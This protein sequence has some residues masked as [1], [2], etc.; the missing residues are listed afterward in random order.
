MIRHCSTPGANSKPNAA[1]PPLAR[2]PSSPRSNR[3]GWPSLTAASPPPTS[4]AN[5]CGSHRA[6]RS[7]RVRDAELL[8]HEVLPS[9]APAAG[10]SIPLLAEAQADG[11]ISPAHARVVYTVIEK[12]PDEI[13]DEH[14]TDIE[15]FL[16][17]PGPRVR[18]G[19]ARPSVAERLRATLDPDGTCQRSGPSGPPPRAALPPPPRRIGPPRSRVDRRVRRAPR[20]PPRRALPSRHR[21]RTAP[22]IRAPRPNA[23]TTPCCEM[24]KLV[25]RAGL[26]PKTAGVCATILLHMDAEAFTTGEGVGDHRARV[27]GPGRD[28]PRTGPDPKRASCSILLSKTRRIEAYSTIH[29]LFTEQQR[30]AMMARDLGCSFPTCDTTPLWTEAHHVTEYQDGGADEHRQRRAR[31]RCNTTASSSRWAGAASSSTASRGGSRPTG[32]TPQHR[33]VQNPLQRLEAS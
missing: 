5:C 20:D 32:S 31:L 23:A 29:R 24:L 3:A 16:L 19:P 18:P 13:A 11:V 30:L 8:D 4:P 28:Q 26:L 14:D 12:L 7:A 1:V 33:P 10:R 15:Q 25:E 6:T 2:T 27:R 21:P 17:G 9:A 22:P